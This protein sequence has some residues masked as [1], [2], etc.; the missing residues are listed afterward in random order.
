MPLRS[1]KYGFGGGGDPRS[2]IR[3]KTCS[4][5]WIPDPRV[6]KEADTQ[7]CLTPSAGLEGETLGGF[8]AYT[9]EDAVAAMDEALHR[10][11]A[12]AVLDFSLS[13]GQVIVFFIHIHL[14]QILLV[15]ISY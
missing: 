15:E 11:P 6:K 13:P 1:Q 7:H 3:K 8:V 2:W 10:L 12:Q 14:F 5:S 9:R 4:G